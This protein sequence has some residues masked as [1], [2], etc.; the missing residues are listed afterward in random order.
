MDQ[1]EDIEAREIPTTK[2]KF[3]IECTKSQYVCVNCQP[4]VCARVQL[5]EPGCQQKSEGEYKTMKTLILHIQKTAETGHKLKRLDIHTLHIVF[6]TDESFANTCGMRIKL[7]YS[8]LMNY[9]NGTSNLVHSGSN[10]CRSVTRSVMGSEL[11]ELISLFDL[12]LIIGN[13][14]KVIIGSE[15]TLEV[16]VESKVVLDKV[17]KDCNT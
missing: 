1:K 14:I 5:I 17:A 13:M 12:A 8:I 4:D 9:G 10:R 7:G 6:L 15:V 16:F 11:N 3:S 2:L